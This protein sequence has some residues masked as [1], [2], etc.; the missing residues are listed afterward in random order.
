MNATLRPV[1]TV[2]IQE[3]NDMLE[4]AQQKVEAIRKAKVQHQE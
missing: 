1:V 4:R 3:V 2:K